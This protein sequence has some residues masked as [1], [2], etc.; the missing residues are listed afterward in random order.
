MQKNLP[1]VSIIV[2]EYNAQDYL[3]LSLPAIR[4]SNYPNYELI[5][6][7]DNSTDL[8]LE[9]A[10]QFAHL[11]VKNPSRLGPGQARNLGVA[12]SRGSILIFLD[13]DVKVTQDT[14][15][16]LVNILLGDSE[17]AAVFGSYDTDPSEKNFMSQYKNLHHHYVHQTGKADASTFWSGCGAVWKKMFLA[18]GGFSSEY[19]SPSIE[20]V[21][22]GYK[23]KESGSKIRLAK[24]AQ[25][26][27]LKHWSLFGLIKT[28]IFDRAKPWT[29]LAWKRGL[30]RDLNFTLAD[31][32][33]G[34]FAGLLFLCLILCGFRSFFFIPV[35]LL[36]ATLLLLHFKLYRFFARRKGIGFAVLAVLYHW[37]YFWYSSLAFL[38]FSLRYVWR[39]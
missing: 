29:K 36:S 14:V 17:I 26:T 6:V 13:A 19:A 18:M 32:C 24:D 3:N 21:E 2:P 27:H 33:S 34:L 37:F 35:L 10:E 8:S 9:T 1:L 12:A 11:V 39:R 31:R 5:V 20:D 28:D 7:D 4:Q 15:A 23:I 38:F 30:P 22:L 25:V 16:T